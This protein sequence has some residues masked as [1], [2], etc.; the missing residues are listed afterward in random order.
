MILH[1]IKVEN[2]R[3]LL[4]ETEVGPFSDRLNVLY[5]PNATGKSTLFEALRC[6]LMDSHNTK[7]KEA[8][9]L[10]PWGRMLSPKVNVEFSVGG[11][12]YRLSKGFLQGAH[13]KLERFEKDAFRPLAE[14]PDADKFTRGLFTKT[15]AKSGISSS[16]QWGLFQVLWAPQGRL[17]LGGLSGDLLSDIRQALSVSVV[18]SRARDLEEKLQKRYDYFFTSTGKVKTA[19]GASPLAPLEGSIRVKEGQ[20]EAK[21]AEYEETQALS[22]SVKALSEK[23]EALRGEARQSESDLRDLE[24]KA[25]GYQALLGELHR[26]EGEAKAAEAEHG[27]LKAFLDQ[28]L[29]LRGDLAEA[30]KKLSAL[31]ISVP[32]LETTLAGCGEE[33]EKAREAVSRALAAKEEGEALLARAREARRFADLSEKLGKLGQTLEDVAAARAALDQVEAEKAG[34]AFPGLTEILKIRKAFS[35]LEEAQMQLD[36]SLITLEIVP[37]ADR[38]GSVESGEAP[39]PVKL[40]AGLE[41]RVQGAPEVR[42]AIEGFGRVR[43]FG[44]CESAEEARE[45]A[46][47]SRAALA[48]L[49]EPYGTADKAALEELHQEGETLK[50][51]A[52]RET[53]RLKA[54]LGKD[55]LESLLAAR[56]GLAGEQNGILERF[57]DWKDS[58]PNPETLES[59]ARSKTT[60]A[61]GA[62]RLA[63]EAKSAAGERYRNTERD[64]DRE[65]QQRDSLE[66]SRKGLE[67]K[68][69][70]LEADG[71]SESE[72]HS[73]LR[74]LALSWDSARGRVEE[75]K[76]QLA[77]LGDDP[78]EALR[79]A[80]EAEKAQ[81]DELRETERF[82]DRESARL[83]VASARGLYSEIA[84][85]EEELENLRRRYG[86]EK[87]A[88]DSIR[89]L[90]ETYSAC[91]SEMALAVN[92]AVEGRATEIVSRIAGNP[93]GR[94]VLDESMSPSGFIPGDAGKAV[95]ME[96]LSGGE[97]EQVHFAVRLALAAATGSE[98]RQLL[99]LDDTLMATDGLRFPRILEIL[100]EASE[101]L[102]VLVLTCQPDRFAPL[103]GASRF[104]LEALRAR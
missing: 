84:S 81:N 14:G 65:R 16:G 102:Q 62:L 53:D 6:A 101:N 49:A 97:S 61:A 80:R 44:P 78:V 8:E 21:K 58:A 32:A 48:E 57:P 1:S 87:L 100:E 29:G 70:R 34:R 73:E 13:S 59:E 47:Q 5:A 55:S 54:I 67:E 69:A 23:L 103:A 27:R 7:A 12:R 10:R 60:E 40:A 31:G 79:R 25:E 30:L 42:L 90:W 11:I 20:F 85:L 3:C 95:G 37:E 26:R 68:L 96:A 28:V 72:R 18:D 45:V 50:R 94:L 43:A 99:V 33:V 51:R 92:R 104:D 22:V 93:T 24:K 9:A 89:L 4:G 82:F 63:E 74:A 75:F 36:A 56:E 52:E 91:R 2:W 71:K 17:E 38:A 76:K 19:A 64:L 86:E 88:A 35:A 77:D 15:P 41:T 98:E 46:S 83:E 39:G 66:E